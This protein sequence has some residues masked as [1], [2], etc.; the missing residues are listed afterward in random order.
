M[1][2]RRNLFRDPPRLPLVAPSILSADFARL[3]EACSHALGPAADGGAGADLLH[4]DVM[5]GHFV[6]NLTMGPAI[7]AGLRRAMPGAFLDVHLMVTDPQQYVGGFADAGADHLTFHLEPAVDPRAGAGLAPLSEGY[8]A[9]E[10][11]DRIREAG[12]SAGLAV[13]PATP[14]DAV[15][16]IASSFELI[17]IMSVNPGFSGQRFMEHTLDKTRAVRT[18]VGDI[19]RVQMDGGV[20]PENAAAVREAGCDV[21]VAASAVFGAPR[22]A[23]AG[24]VAELRGAPE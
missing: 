14:V 19:V 1:A 16:D 18:A 8:D 20:A 21:L 3:G 9:V 13:N 4:V 2:E 5:D 6:P 24:V 11:A 10:L 12:M 7:V 15:L 22:E 23:R 17:L